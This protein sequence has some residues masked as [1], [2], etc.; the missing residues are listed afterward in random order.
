MVCICVPQIGHEE[1]GK[2]FQLGFGNS[3][4][5]VSLPEALSCVLGEE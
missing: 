1:R 5:S 2:H 3:S 4:I